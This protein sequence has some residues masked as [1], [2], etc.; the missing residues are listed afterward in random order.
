DR[1]QRT[2]VPPAGGARIGGGAPAGLVHHDEGLHERLALADRLEAAL[3]VRARRIGTVAEFRDG[4]VERQG[5]ERAG[6]VALPHGGHHRYP[7]QL[8]LPGWSVQIL[9]SSRND[10]A[11]GYAAVNQRAQALPVAFQAGG[12]LVARASTSSRSPSRPPQAMRCGWM[13]IAKQRPNA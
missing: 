9:G 11:G 6:V 8:R 1:R 4:V 10:V 13:V 12:P 7:F 3:Q 5:A 2:T